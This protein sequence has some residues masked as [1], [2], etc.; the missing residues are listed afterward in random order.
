MAV[1]PTQVQ[2]ISD[3][4]TTLVPDAQPFIDDATA[5][6][7]AI[8]TT[9]LTEAQYD[10][11]IK[12]MAAHLIAMKDPL[13]AMEQV[14]SISQSVQ[15][16]LADGLGITR[17]GTMAMAFD[18]TGKLARWNQSVI[19]GGGRLQFFWAGTEITTEEPA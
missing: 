7:E 18:I 10:L 9:G 11:V 1:T 2:Q 12:Y 19:A 4:D 17:Y 13:V 16:R 8:I 15:Y 14:R 5:L 3:Y 6:V